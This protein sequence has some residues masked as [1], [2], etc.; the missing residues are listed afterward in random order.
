M[1]LSGHTRTR[2]ALAATASAALLIGLPATAGAM[3]DDSTLT[4]ATHFVMAADGSS[5]LTAHGKGIPNIDSVKSTIRAYYNAPTGI[6]NKTDSPYITE[7]KAMEAGILAQI[8]TAP[9]P[10]LAVV[11]DADDTTLWTYD[12]EDGAMHFNFDPTLQGT[13][14]H[15]GLF[16]ATPGMVDFVKAVADKGYNVYGL[17]GRGESQEA[18]TLANLSKVGYTEFNADN[19][20]TKF[21]SADTKPA[22]LDCH[23]SVDPADDPAKCT[24]VEYKAGT[25]KHI[26]QDLGQTI[27][28]NIGDQWSDLQGGYA[29]HTVKLPNPT[30][31]LPSPDI[32]GAPS[33]DSQLTPK[34]EF[35]MQPD[36]SSGKTVGG[37]NIPNIDSV[38]STI[39]TYYGAPS[40]LANAD[41]SPYISDLSNI[42]N[43]WTKRLTNRCAR[44]VAHGTKPAVVFDAD[45]TTL[46]TYNMEDAAM[47][48]N[49]DPTLQNT[50][51]QEGR[52]PAVPGMPAVVNAAKAAG[53]KIIGLTG[54][55]NAQRVATLDNLAKYYYDDND[56]ALFKSQ[57]YFTKWTS[58][59]T[60]P[61]YIDC[62]QDSDATKCSTIEYKSSTRKYVEDHFG[63]HIIANFGDQFS[64]LIGQHSDNVIKL[65]NP[66]YYL[67]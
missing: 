52:F 29:L 37:E 25:R 5:G 4:P 30:Y 58:T 24:T 47:H 65:P 19:F 63:F 56:N 1:R 46:W 8:P 17:T 55:N 33:T 9:A 51:V 21:G 50:W 60:P 15:D 10:N 22:Y 48:F 45:D 32:Q 14:V 12:M 67:P 42:E 26:E 62:A 61:A 43:L 6:A 57:Y 18:D 7:M 16:P 23:T 2:A 28:L 49:F 31:Y 41:T 11:F 38:K 39:R 53:C 66:T 3:T 40:G 13:W 64:D 36:G 35:D 44:G 20:F 27:V 59:D 34:T 54:R